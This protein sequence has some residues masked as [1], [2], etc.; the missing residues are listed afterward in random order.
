MNKSVMSKNITQRLLTNIV[1][2]DTCW[3]WVGAQTGHGEYGS[4]VIDGKDRR[5]HRVVYTLIR[6]TI[7]NGLDLD[8]LCRVRK[9]CN[10][11]HLEPVTKGEN[12]LRGIGLAAQ[13]RA[14]THCLHGHQF[15]P[16]NT[17]IYLRHGRVTRNCRTCQSQ[18]EV[19]HRAKLSTTE[20]IAD[21]YRT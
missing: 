4:I 2:T 12:V 15:T 7:P 8:H 20:R 17:Y 10:P 3:L 6:G 1:F 13:N 18:R 9:C 19:R 5:V 21:N 16:G 11:D 14:K